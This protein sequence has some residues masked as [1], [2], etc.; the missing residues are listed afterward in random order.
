MC[1][2]L[3]LVI[4]NENPK[5]KL[6]WRSQDKFIIEDAIED[7]RKCIARLVT[8]LS[9]I[10][11]Q[12]PLYNKRV[13]NMKSKGYDYIGPILINDLTEFS[14]Y[15]LN[16]DHPITAEEF[17]KE[18]S[19]MKNTLKFDKLYNNFITCNKLAKVSILTTQEYIRRAMHQDKIIE[20]LEKEIKK[21]KKI[22]GQ[23]SSCL[24][25]TL[26]MINLAGSALSNDKN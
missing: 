17:I 14:K 12:L 23:A 11:K 22:L 10:F 15:Y 24:D 18:T 1:N 20:Q 13:D 19:T 9:T 6:E 4:T 3:S 21:N 26:K 7:C 16:D 8:P 25:N 2:S 5:Y